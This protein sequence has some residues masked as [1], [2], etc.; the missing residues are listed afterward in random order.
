MERVPASRPEER[1]HPLWNLYVPAGQ[2]EG[3][4]E[5]LGRDWVALLDAPEAREA[6]SRGDA[7]IQ[8]DQEGDVTCP[9]CGHVFRLKPGEADCPDCGLSLGVPETP[10]QD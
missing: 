5:A 3:A 6:A 1:Q 4:L 10:S 7:G 8:L 2:L 9:A